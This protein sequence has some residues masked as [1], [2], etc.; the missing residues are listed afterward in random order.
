MKESPALTVPGDLTNETIDPVS[1]PRW[2][3]LAA[4]APGA[5]IFH[6][7]AWIGLLADQY[8][9]EP[10]AW[11]LAEGAGG[12]LVAGLP[13][14][15]VST[16]LTSARLVALPFSDVCPPLVRPG[17][18]AAE[19]ELLRLV[20]ERQAEA[21]LPLQV[22]A[23]LDLDGVVGGEPYSHHLLALGD[24]V[25][26]VRSR[27]RSQVR[28][29]ISKAER[30]ELQTTRETDRRALDDFYGLHLRTRRRQGVPTQPR[31]FIRG[32]EALFDQ[33]LGFVQVARLDGQAVAAAVFLVASGTITYKY[34][35]S[36]VAHQALRPNNLLFMG[37]IAWACEHGQ[38]ELDFGRTDLEN[39]GLR[40]FKSSWGAEERTLTYSS[41]G[42]KEPESG[43][44]RAERLLGG[45][46]RRSPPVV[47]RL[48]GEAFYRHAG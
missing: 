19:P 18:D 48:V 12:R 10:L 21:G 41:L 11:V 3:D 27:F 24:D 2:G 34:G 5:S 42:A 8:G 13:V 38:R 29:N 16:R 43:H 36:D 44:G 32:F 25:D 35:A 22:R 15:R 20:A 45:V 28:R 30:S 1:D 47:G 23:P 40:K 17:H 46:I 4:Q 39:E 33:G 14:T 9:Y 6:H 31:S 26:E 37:A 7:P